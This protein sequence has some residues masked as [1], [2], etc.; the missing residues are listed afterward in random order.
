M[1]YTGNDRGDSVSQI[2]VGLAIRA[3]IEICETREDCSACPISGVCGGATP[4]EWHLTKVPEI[5]RY[6]A[7]YLG[8]REKRCTEN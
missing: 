8:V 4:L 3:I 6:K 2:D 1:G 7:V 5:G